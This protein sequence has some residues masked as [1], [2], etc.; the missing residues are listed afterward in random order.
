MT[1]AEYQTAALRT[2]GESYLGEGELSLANCALGVAGEAGE[3]ADSIKK[4]LAQ[5]HSF[6]RDI[7]VEELGDLLWQINAAAQRIGASLEEVAETNIRKVQNRY[8]NGF[9]TEASVNRER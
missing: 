7:L 2:A 3:F 1:F 6:K 9:S 4:I 5:G 8:P